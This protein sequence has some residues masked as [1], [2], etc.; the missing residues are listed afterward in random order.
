MLGALRGWLNSW[1]AKGLFVLLI[2]SFA[3]WGVGDFVGGGG[4]PSSVATV[5]G[6]SISVEEATEAYRRDLTQLQRSFG[7][8]FE[9]VAPLRRRIA[10]DA[11][12]RL[13]TLTAIAEEAAARGVAVTDEAL[14]QFIFTAEPFRGLDGSFNRVAFDSFLRN[15]G[16]SE[17]R[18]LL[19]LR[20][21]IA[22]QQVLMAVRAGAAGPSAMAVPILAFQGEQRDARVV[23]MRF[24]AAAAPPEPSEEQ[25][26]RFHANEAARFT[27]PEYRR[28]QL[29]TLTVEQVAREITPT[30]DQLRAAYDA[31]RA[32]Y[33]LPERRTIE[34]ALVNDEILARSLAQ[35]WRGGLDFAA[36][37]AQAGSAGGSA[38]ALGTVSREDLPDAAI[39]AAAFDAAEGAVTDPVRSDFGWHVLR[40]TAIA[41]GQTRAFASVREELAGEVARELAAERIYTVANRVE[42]SIAEG[43]PLAE[44]ARRH[45]LG[46]TEIAA[47]DGDGRGP[48]GAPLDL[49]AMARPI[50]DSVF[51]TQVGTTSRLVEAEGSNFFATRVEDIT[52]PALRPFESIAA[53]VKTAWE[54]AERRRAM[55][56]QA[57]QLLAAVQGGTPFEAAATAQGWTPRRIGPFLRNSR[58]AGTPPPQLLQAIFGMAEGEATM[59]EANQSFIVVAVGSITKPDVTAADRLAPVRAAIAA[60]MADDLEAQFAQ[61]IQAASRPTINARALDLMI[62]TDP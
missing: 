29:L 55:E 57:A 23:E 21:D 30:E 54:N 61:A 43:I 59:I 36:I 56:G 50:V 48:D 17:A 10:E 6:R 7:G 60:G 12:N 2:L 40:V 49:G 27:A 26:R 44:V 1:V 52:Q 3:V 35:A 47:M 46:F 28:F 16:L 41:A 33:V 13:I 38:A 25:L 22:R 37:E 53:E 14:R 19:L 31:R 32:E 11:V 45:A 8:N 4:A 51:G 62:G 42:D 58:G 39:A 9:P 24:I 20:G 5:G 34:Q 18:F 15:A